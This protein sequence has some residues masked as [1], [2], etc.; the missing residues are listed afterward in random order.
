MLNQCPS[1]HKIISQ[2][3]KIITTKMNGQ[4]RYKYFVKHHSD[5]TTNSL[6][7]I[8]S[9]ALVLYN[10]HYIC[11]VWWMCFSTDSWNSYGYNLRYPSR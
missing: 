5:F 9:N 2:N 7:Q 3:K 1:P 10:L 4:R 6:K 11:H 8:S